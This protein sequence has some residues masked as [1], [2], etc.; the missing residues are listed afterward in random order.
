MGA[1]DLDRGRAEPDIVFIPGAKGAILDP[2]SDAEDF[3]LTKMGIDATKFRHTARLVTEDHLY[4]PAERVA[5]FC[6]GTHQARTRQ[7]AKDVPINA[8]PEAVSRVTEVRLAPDRIT[9]SLVLRP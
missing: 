6:D 1:R 4:F 8:K 7:K 9:P 5:A 2:T 3:T